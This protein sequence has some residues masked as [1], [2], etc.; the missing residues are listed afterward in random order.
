MTFYFNI[1]AP[2]IEAHG[3]AARR[4]KVTFSG[5]AAYAD[6]KINRIRAFI[7]DREII[8]GDYGQP[9]QDVRDTLRANGV[10]VGINTGFK[11]HLPFYPET[12]AGKI[13]LYFEGEKITH[14]VTIPYLI[15]EEPEQD[16]EETQIIDLRYPI[17]AAEDVKE[18]AVLKLDHVGDFIIALPHLKKLRGF[19]HGAHVTLIVASWNVELAEASGVADKVVAFDHFNR[20]SGTPNHGNSADNSDIRLTISDTVFDLAVDFRILDDTQ[21]I[22]K[23]L[24]S[25]TYAGFSS[26]DT[27]DLDIAVRFPPNQM[28]VF[29]QQAVDDYMHELLRATMSFFSNEHNALRRSFW[30]GFPKSAPLFFPV[31][32]R[33]AYAIIHPFAGNPAK[34]WGTENY[35]T[36]ARYLHDRHGLPSL[37]LGH[38]HEDTDTK[39]LEALPYITDLVGRTS[40]LQLVSAIGSA[41]IFVGCD[42]GPRHIAV[43]RGVPSVGIF[44]GINDYTLWGSLGEK[45]LIVRKNMR[46]APCYIDSIDFCHRAF[47]CIR[48]IK[49]EE[50][51]PAID[52]ILER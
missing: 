36:V 14:C 37:L 6:Q 26:M 38:S 47:A 52:R 5:W 40:L 25:K 10:K 48:H 7:N 18:I 19:F 11:V 33:G 51:F 39:T 44:S 49:P 42:S 21:A 41:N 27:C 46:C 24:N 43:S 29:R 20:V 35:L 16:R 45:N 12:T 23:Q 9:R 32:A 2:S 22:L 31:P 1:D 34:Q 3:L 17:R 8:D 28:Q 4:G 30:D 15:E 13:L 50:V